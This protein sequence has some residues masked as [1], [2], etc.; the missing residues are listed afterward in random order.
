RLDHRPLQ[1]GRPGPPAE[2]AAKAAVIGIDIAIPQVLPGGQQIDGVG[3]ACHGPTQA[4]QGAERQSLSA[5]RD[6]QSRLSPDFLSALRSRH[7]TK[8][9]QN[10]VLNQTPSTRATSGI[11]G[12]YCAR[13]A[14]VSSSD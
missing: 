11:H 10:I 4:A 8:T 1:Q 2:L 6:V 3:K 13:N 7:G 9:S 14:L 5:I 12:Q